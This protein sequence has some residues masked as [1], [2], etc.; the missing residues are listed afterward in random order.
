MLIL[1]LLLL[2][3]GP[4]VADDLIPERRKEQFQTETGYAILPIPYS[5]PGIGA[6]I[7]IAGGV[8]NAGGS[9]VD[10]YGMVLGGDVQ[11]R[12]IGIADLH[13]IPRHLIFDIGSSQIDHATINNYSSRGMNTSRDDYTIIGLTDTSSLGGRM[14][15]S[16]GDRRYELYTARYIVESRLDSIRDQDG[17]IIVKAQDPPKNAGDSNI[18]G[19]RLDLTDDYDDPRRGLRLDFSGWQTPKRNI[20]SEYM[21]LDF[22]TTLYIPVGLRSTWVFNFLKSDA[23]VTKK[24]VTDRAIIEQEQGLYCSLI[25][26]PQQKEFCD[27]LVDNMIAENTYGT[28]T[29]LGGFSRLRGYPQ[30]RYKGAHTRFY[31]T[32]LRWNLTDEFTPFD[33]FVIKDVRTSVQVAFFFEVAT[34]ADRAKDIGDEYRIAHGGGVRLVTASGLVFRADLAMGTEGIQPNMFIGYPWEF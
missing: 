25:A 30:G 14:T 18:F 23:T 26:D 1:T 6:G 21:V 22:N 17:D 13:L 9:Y 34:I 15:L 8:S 27:Q 28:A 20:A 2:F 4:V 32:E 24:G 29:S 31:G 33:W 19:A 12:A 7:S 5:L 11:G 16:F 3:T 10:A